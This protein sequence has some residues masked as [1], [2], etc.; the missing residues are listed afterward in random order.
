MGAHAATPLGRRRLLLPLGA[1]HGV[2]AGEALELELTALVEAEPLARH[3]AERRG[4]QHLPTAG[5]GRDSD[6]PL[7]RD[8]P[9]RD[10]EHGHL[11]RAGRELQWLQQLLGN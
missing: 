4:N 5:A 1:E 3:V 2:R 10:L 7:S 9:G 8:F 6:R 11:W